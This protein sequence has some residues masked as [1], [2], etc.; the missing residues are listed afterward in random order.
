MPIIYGGILALLLAIAAVWRVASVGE[1]AA[2][3][4]EAM[5]AGIARLLIQRQQLRAAVWLV[6]LAIVFGSVALVLSFGSMRTVGTFGFVFAVTIAA[7]FL[8]RREIAAIVIG[9]WVAILALTWIEV[10][11][12]TPSAVRPFS[13]PH[14][15]ILSMGMLFVSS[16]VGYA[17]SV[18][19]AAVRKQ[20][21]EL[22][23]R[24]RAEERLRLSMEATRQGWFDLDLA[25]GVVAASPQ[26]ARLIGATPG[27]SEVQLTREAWI[28]AIHHD[29]RTQVME[30]LDR[31]LRT[32]ETERIEYRLKGLD[33]S[34]RWIRS[35]AKVVA[36][37]GAGRPA[38]LT[39]THADIT[40]Q[41]ATTLALESSERSY[42]ALVEMSPVGVMV[43]RKGD[44]RYANPAAVGLMGATD[45]SEL[46][47][48]A[49][50]S[51]LLEDPPSW[52]LSPGEC[53]TSRPEGAPAPMEL[54][55]RGLKGNT[56]EASILCTPLIHEGTS[57]LQVSFTDISAQKSAEAARL[58]SRQLE[59]LGTLA[60]GIAHD[61]NNILLAIRGNAELVANEPGLSV[62]GAEQLR[63][64][65]LA[66]Q[67]ASELVRRITT[68]ARPREPHQEL[69]QLRDVLDEV[70]R[71]LRPTVPAGISFVVHTDDPVLPIMADAAA[72]HE[73]IVNLTTNA[74]Y[75]IGSGRV[76]EV[77]FAVDHT[78]LQGDAASV[79]GVVEGQYTRLT[80]HDTGPGMS[81]ETQ[82][83]LFD[84]FYTT[85]PVG[86][87]SGLG[88]SMAYGIMRSHGGTITVSSREGHGATFQLLFPSV[89]GVA[90]APPALSPVRAA[91]STSKRVLFVDDEPPL[92]RLAHRTLTPLGHTVT[93]FTCPL[94]ALEAFR[95]SPDAFD[96]VI[97][98][99]SMP[100][101][102][103]L[104]LA[105]TLR[106]EGAAIPIV[107]VTG[108]SDDVDEAEAR[109]AGVTRVAVKAATAQQLPRLL[110]EVAH[111]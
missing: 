34:F 20:Q 105:K 13:W 69:I 97:T 58:T 80:V 26:F 17:R 91:T 14:A 5:A 68:F 28:A 46:L 51:F 1:L 24:H 104:A 19:V 44:V 92:V 100:R 93:S 71:L 56:F 84:A 77:T 4:F 48:V 72:V 70:L 102:S 66:G 78:M 49:M 90:V 103:G 32:G 36:H 85:K 31:C 42:R 73:T 99:L 41:M 15:I 63:E 67:R 3:G 52:L 11:R 37:D 108:Y 57:S 95:V 54:L 39:G 62:D 22:D 75:A 83:R 61:F 50:R 59:A 29:D 12:V 53:L 98:D 64:I 35:T 43:V 8:P 101:M 30:R 45:A 27:D 47:G 33:G 10:S 111:G 25:T 65:L 109:A 6:V 23:E 38:R 107:M 94:E 81:S 2:L 7:V 110:A 88:L 40:D 79:A 86:E 18:A 82:R 55:L 21:V 76:G 16:V 89:E 106:R 60:G 96:V 87:G 74:V 9:V